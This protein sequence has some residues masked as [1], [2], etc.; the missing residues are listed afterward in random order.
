MECNYEDMNANDPELDIHFGKIGNRSI[1][2]GI[3]NDKYRKYPDGSYVY[4]GFKDED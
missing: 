4:L 1:Y 3:E 2:N